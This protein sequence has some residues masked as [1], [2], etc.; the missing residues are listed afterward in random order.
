MFYV[1]LG[2]FILQKP[3]QVVIS[4]AKW[5][6]TS[7]SPAQVYGGQ[8][9]CGIWPLVHFSSCYRCLFVC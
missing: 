3:A 2:R 8:D 7:I 4:L 5:L 6:A 9:S 1:K